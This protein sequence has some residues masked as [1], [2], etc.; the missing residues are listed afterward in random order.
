MVTSNEPGF[1]RSGQYGIRTEN[2]M[3]CVEDQ[4]TD[5]G[6]FYRFDTLTL[7]PIDRQ[8]MDFSLLTADEI[9][10]IN[11]YHAEVHAGISPLLADAAELDWLQRQCEVI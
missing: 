9:A 6:T 1:Y 10:W 3:L 4:R 8:L 5:F 11:A 7:F 2:L